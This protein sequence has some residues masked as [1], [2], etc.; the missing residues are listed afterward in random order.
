MEITSHQLS[1]GKR[2]GGKG[3]GWKKRGKER[4]RKAG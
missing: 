2:K 1:T 3:E 4:E